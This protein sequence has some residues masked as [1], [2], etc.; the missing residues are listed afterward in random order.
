M[1][2]LVGLLAAALTTGAWLPQIWRTWRTR[3]ARDLS[4]GYLAT[5]CLGFA[6]WLTYGL[7]TRDPVIIIANVTT[8]VLLAVLTTLKARP[9]RMVPGRLAEAALEPA[10]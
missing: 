8:L 7:M 2:V 5:T 4:W 9:V 3:S 10:A 1:T 6:T